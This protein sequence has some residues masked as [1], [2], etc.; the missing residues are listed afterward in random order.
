ML[1]LQLKSELTSKENGFVEQRD[2]IY[3]Q[4]A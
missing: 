4:T 2:S 3:E 1:S